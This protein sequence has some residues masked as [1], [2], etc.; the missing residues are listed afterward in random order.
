MS[1]WNVKLT[2]EFKQEIRDIYS[3]IANT[4]LV[5][6]T[7]LNQVDRI[8]KAVE[9]LDEMSQRYPLYDREPWKTRELRK[10]VVD[11]FVVFYLT[12][13]K[14]KDVVIFHVFYG[15]RNIAELLEKK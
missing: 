6:K 11:N 15:G 13:E 7:A 12:N 14:L 1:Q 2:P 9:A 5:P 10:L 8:L 4:L 3:Y